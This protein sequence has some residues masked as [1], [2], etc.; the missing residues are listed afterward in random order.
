MVVLGGWFVRVI[1]LV[2]FVI[3]ERTFIDNCF[4]CHIKERRTKTFFLSCASQG[5]GHKIYN[6]FIIRDTTKISINFLYCS[7]ER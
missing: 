7:K 2:L 5:V 4:F 6:F 1:V 3:R